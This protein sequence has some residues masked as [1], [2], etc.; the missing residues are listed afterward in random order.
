M[1]NRFSGFPPQMPTFFR[2]LEKNNDRAWFVPRKAL[3]E[4]QVRAPMIALV[5]ILNDR[6][7]K[8]SPDHVGDD[9]ARLIYRIYRDTRF[10]KDKTP[11]K[12]HLGATF[13]PRSLSRHAGAGFYF[14]ISHRWVGIAG[15]VYMPGPEDLA[16]IRT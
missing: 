9:P 4:E 13:R 6:M 2:A 14:E 7:R 11:Y 12:T 5:T 15:G 16:A 3:F 8:L 1:S 10:S